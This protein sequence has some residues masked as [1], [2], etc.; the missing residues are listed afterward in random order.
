MQHKTSANTHDQAL[1]FDHLVVMMR[2]QLESYAPH[3]EHDGYTLTEVSVHN[4][5]SMNRL[6]AL[7]TSY[8]ELLGWP[9]GTEPKR[10]EIA[11]QALGL[12]ALVFRSNDAH[13]TR[14]RLLERGYALNEVQ[15]L[16]R[17][18][19]FHGEEGL[20]CFDTLRFA[21]QPVAGLRMYFCQHL[22]PQYV[23]DPLVMQHPNGVRD[24]HEIEVEAANAPAVASVLADLANA[25]TE[26]QGA[27]Y[28]VALP[29][30]QLRVRQVAGLGQARLVAAWVK[31][32]DGTTTRFATHLP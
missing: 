24:L 8:I 29:N 12:D 11:A 28:V 4:L 1:S 26:Q 6:I 14:K 19:Q 10:Q 5:G 22:T 7:D 9:T 3:I 25:T 30:L 17:P 32:A 31:H 23:W 20:A 16:E 21:K 13:A 15:R 27:D 18:L 2:D